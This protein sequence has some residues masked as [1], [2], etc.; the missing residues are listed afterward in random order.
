MVIDQLVQHLKH[1]ER[2]TVTED[3]IT[4]QR[5]TAPTKYTI[6]AAEVIVALYSDNQ[7]LLQQVQQLQNLLASAHKDCEYFC[8][9][10]EKKDEES[11]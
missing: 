3:D 2:Y 5:I 10:L 4:V 6:K 7:K 8:S 11:V 1:G 9:Q